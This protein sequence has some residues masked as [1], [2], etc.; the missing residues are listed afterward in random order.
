MGKCETEFVTGECAGELHLGKFSSCLD[1]ALYGMALED[2]NSGCGDSD[3]R[4][5]KSRVDVPDVEEFELHPDGADSAVV[6]V[7]A[8][9]YI[10][11]TAPTGGVTVTRY[12]TEEE[13]AT[14]YDEWEAA[15]NE[16]DDQA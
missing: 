11:Y 13:A 1:E 12:E 5:Y 6:K 16:W 8:G 9:F 10:V 2:V 3:W 15:Y 14:E 7:P 4:G